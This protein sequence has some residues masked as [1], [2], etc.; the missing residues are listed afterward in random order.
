[1][2][3]KAEAI[4]AEERREI[5][6]FGQYPERFW[7]HNEYL[8]PRRI[9]EAYEAALTASE[10]RVKE[11]EEEVTLLRSC[12]QWVPTPPGESYAGVNDLASAAFEAL[13]E[14]DER[15]ALARGDV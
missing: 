12:L 8:V 1:M 5:A 4:T 14:H 13:N 15:T 11:L 10:Q 7:A 2:T 9:A 6:K 3:S